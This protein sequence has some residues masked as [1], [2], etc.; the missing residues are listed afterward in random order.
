MRPSTPSS[1]STIA[2]RI[3]MR[4]VPESPFEST[5]TLALAVGEWYVDLRVDRQS[6]G[7]DWALAGECRL[8]NTNPRRVVFTHVIDSHRKFNVSQPCPFV[9]LSNG[10][11]M[12]TGTMARLD[13]EGAP[14][15]DYEEI[16]RYLPLRE[17]PEAFGGNTSWVLQSVEDVGEGRYPVSKEFLAKVGRFYL[18]L[19]QEQS[20]VSTRAPEGKWT[21]DITGEQVS[22]R[23]EEWLGDHWEEKYVLGLHG[24]RLPSM[25]KDLIGRDQSWR[26]TP[27]EKV[28]IRGSSY[29]VRGV[30]AILAIAAKM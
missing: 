5:N 10:D 1:N 29:V 12:E 9:P 15:T 27:G 22:A 13:R 28:S 19:H 7:I 17:V 3:S 21:V 4:W 30:E 23:R 18:V 14:M 6:A 8:V 25:A 24:G 11:D 16:W 20:Q 26:W 2:A